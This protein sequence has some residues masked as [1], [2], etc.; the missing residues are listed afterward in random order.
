M[1]RRKINL[2]IPQCGFNNAKNVF[3]SNFHNVL[4]DLK[5]PLCTE[6]KKINENLIAKGEM[7]YNLLNRFYILSTFV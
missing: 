1:Q 2:N 7:N 3:A 4:R 5:A 6:N